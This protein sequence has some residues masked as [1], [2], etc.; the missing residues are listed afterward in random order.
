LI[1]KPVPFF[2]IDREYMDPVPP[3]LFSQSFF[4]DIFL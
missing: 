2:V 3:P 1:S 4:Y